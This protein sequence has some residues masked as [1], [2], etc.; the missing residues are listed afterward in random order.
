MLIDWFTV[1]A[2]IFNFL[3]L[4]WLLKRFLYAPILKALDAREKRI[5][6]ELADAAEKQTEALAER[7]EYRRKNDELEGMRDELLRKTID[8]AAALREKLMSEARSDATS[9]REKNRKSLDDEYQSLSREISRRTQA[10]V[11]AIAKKTLEDLADAALEERMVDVFIVHLKSMNSDEKKHLTGILVK[12]AFELPETARA[13]IVEAIGE[14][15]S[16]GI[17]YEVV[18]ELV[19]GIELV[20]HGQKIAWSV[21]D[22]LGMLEKEVDAL[23]KAQSGSDR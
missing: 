3:I 2:Q 20:A 21:D 11:L 1:I 10:S 18:P 9:M 8:D 17:S 13:R 12:S 4:V 19:S 22:Y 16:V 23:F 5:A 15:S 6:A 7:E 14:F